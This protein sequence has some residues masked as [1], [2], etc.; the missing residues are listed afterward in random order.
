M[1]PRGI[2]GRETWAFVLGFLVAVVTV[3]VFLSFRIGSLH[4]Q[5]MS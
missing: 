2:R 3:G 5:E 4:R 1:G